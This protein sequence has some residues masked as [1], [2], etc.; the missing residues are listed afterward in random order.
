METTILCPTTILKALLQILKRV[1]P[2]EEA[3]NVVCLKIILIFGK[4]SKL[5]DRGI[6]F[7]SRAKDKVLGFLLSSS[8][9][10][11]AIGDNRVNCH[12]MSHSEKLKCDW[13][14]ILLPR[15]AAVLSHSIVHE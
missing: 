15:Q 13:I 12:S 6:P 3:Q 14:Q 9:D 10:L 1:I 11:C 8:K 5:M 4:T 7:S 2:F